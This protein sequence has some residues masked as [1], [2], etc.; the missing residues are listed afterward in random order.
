MEHVFIIRTALYDASKLKFEK[1]D[2]LE[3]FL[4]NRNIGYS[5]FDTGPVFAVYKRLLQEDG[6]DR[7]PSCIIEKDGAKEKYT[8]GWSIVRALSKLKDR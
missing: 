4:K 5:P 3:E 2:E 6:I 1:G 8:G 7:T